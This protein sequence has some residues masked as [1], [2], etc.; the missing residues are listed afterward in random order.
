MIEGEKGILIG[1]RKAFRF[2]GLWEFPGGK[3]EPAET[4][5]ECL[6]RELREEL[7][8][9]AEIGE[10]FLS[11]KYVYSHAPIELL[12][13]KAKIV[14]GR[15]RL[16]DHSELRWVSPEDLPSYEFPPADLP[17]IEKLIQED[18]GMH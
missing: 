10:F 4:A 11:S 2:A 3:V 7:D 16:N 18:R 1:R 5:E 9:E 14:R 17:V 8:I 13:Y 15:P 12:V 6:R